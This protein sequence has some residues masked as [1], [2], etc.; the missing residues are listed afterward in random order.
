MQPY[1]MGTGWIGGPIVS[2][3]EFST[4]L[5]ST[6]SSYELGCIH[7]HCTIINHQSSITT[8]SP[9]VDLD[10]LTNDEIRAVTMGHIKRHKKQLNNSCGSINKNT[11]S[12]ASNAN[13]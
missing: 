12:C 6:D 8:I 1:T 10:S 11:A 3:F 13:T 5:D 9:T 4:H 2:R 7:T